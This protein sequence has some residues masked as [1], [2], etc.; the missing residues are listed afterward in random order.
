M[1]R[2]FKCTSSHTLLN[3]CSSGDLFILICRHYISHEN[4]K[5][6][7]YISWLSMKPYE[8]PNCRI[9]KSVISY[10]R[11]LFNIY[12]YIYIHFSWHEF[13]ARLKLTWESLSLSLFLFLFFLFSLFYLSFSFSLYLSLS[14][15][16]FISLYFIF[17]WNVIPK[18]YYF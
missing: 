5:L 16:L 18:I 12:I 2:I 14:L 13:I 11:L 8:H 15:Y 7:F 1:I 4:F 6:F 17:E 10:R 9:Y 3:G